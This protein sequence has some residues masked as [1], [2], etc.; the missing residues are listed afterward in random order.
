[1]CGAGAQASHSRMMSISQ[2]ARVQAHLERV[3][4]VAPAPEETI[5]APDKTGEPGMPLKTST[6]DQFRQANYSR[7]VLLGGL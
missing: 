6:T 3:G 4:V 1:M 2:S 7:G 5:P